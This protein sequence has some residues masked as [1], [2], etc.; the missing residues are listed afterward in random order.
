MRDVLTRPRQPFHVDWDDGTGPYVLYSFA[1]QNEDIDWG[2]KPGELELTRFSGGRAAMY[3]WTLTVVTKENVSTTTPSPNEANGILAMTWEFTHAIDANGYTTRT[4]S[5]TILLESGQ[6][7]NDLGADYDRTVVTNAIPVPKWFKRTS[8]D[9]H[10]N[11]NGRV[12]SFT[13]VDVEQ[14]LTLP[15]PIT[16]GHADWTIRTP[17][18]LSGQDLIATAT[19]SGYFETSAAH[20]KT[21]LLNA[22][23]NLATVKFAGLPADSSCI[24]GDR[25]IRESVYSNRIEFTISASFA[26]GTLANGQVDYNA[27]LQTVGVAP[28]G[29]DGTA[30]GINAYGQTDNLNSGVVAAT[31]Q[32]FDALSSPQLT[33][34]ANLA[35]IKKRIRRTAL[36]GGETPAAIPRL[37][38]HQSSSTRR[39]S[40]RYTRRI[41]LSSSTKS[42]RTN[43]TTRSRC[44]TPNCPESPRSSSRPPIHH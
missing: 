19:L 12:L 4:T 7:Q 28:P 8:M 38:Y 14:Y 3:R 37:R 32:P 34:A 5:G 43:W 30:I 20:S 9:F 11:P 26:I 39:A 1:A 41:L 36:R 27:G 40:P 16:G 15:I 25:E 6:V 10:Q 21:E 33:N 17:G 22:I 24:P 18:I 13:L 23:Y 42:F 31:P 2:P 35:T 44:S 29:S